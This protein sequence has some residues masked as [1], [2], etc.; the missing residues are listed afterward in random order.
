MRARLRERRASGDRGAVLVEAAFVLPIFLFF[1]FGTIEFGLAFASQSTTTSSTRQGARFAS[2]NF[3]A[4]GNPA[5][6]ADQ[7]RLTMQT[8]IS[9]LTGYDTPVRLWMYHAAPPNTLGAG[10]PIGGAGFTSCNTDCYK[11][12]WNGT[13]FVLDASP[14]WN[15]AAACAPSIDSVGVYLEVNH[16]YVTGAIGTSVLLKEHTTLRLEPL[17]LAQCPQGAQ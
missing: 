14:G 8:Y 7:I 16:N 4:V 12:T 13:Q 6:A 2:A 15:D 11:Y 10:E 5:A 3:A 1:I 17:P 9:A